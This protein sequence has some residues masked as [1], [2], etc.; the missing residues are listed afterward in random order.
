[1]NPNPWFGEQGREGEAKRVFDAA[2]QQHPTD[3]TLLNNLGG[4][5]LRRGE[6]VEAEGLFR[7]SL[8]SSPGFPSAA[9]NL[10][11]LLKAQSEAEQK[12]RSKDEL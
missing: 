9:A 7:R 12:E 8:E 10:E 11:A 3:A 5:H 2:L 4:F 1:V 6:L